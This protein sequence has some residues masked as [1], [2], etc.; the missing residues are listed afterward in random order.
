MHFEFLLLHVFQGQAGAVFTDFIAQKR[1]LTAGLSPAG[2]SQHTGIRARV[3]AFRKVTKTVP[4]T[5]GL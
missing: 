2:V 5:G 4:Y 3:L 1:H